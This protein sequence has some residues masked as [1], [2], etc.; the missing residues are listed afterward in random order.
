MDR[1]TI[2]KKDSE[3]K[4]RVK[5]A[6]GTRSKSGL[7]K[8]GSPCGAHDGRGRGGAA[9]NL[10]GG[11]ASSRSSADTGK[12]GSVHEEFFLA[13]RGGGW[14]CFC[15]HGHAFFSQKR[16]DGGACSLSGRRMGES[17]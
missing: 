3:K 1:R 4:T 11:W 12:S 7:G 17:G 15:S 8:A 14:P 13:H 9:R 6:N 2:Y 5:G 10:L 16:T